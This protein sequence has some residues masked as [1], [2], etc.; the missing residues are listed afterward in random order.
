[1]ETLIWL[2]VVALVGGPLVIAGLVAGA[3]LLV[4]WGKK[5]RSR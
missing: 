3:L 2:G 1:M 5:R 4:R